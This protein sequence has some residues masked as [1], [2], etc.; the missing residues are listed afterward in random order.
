MINHLENRVEAYPPPPI[1]WKV[2]ARHCGDKINFGILWAQQN[3]LQRRD[4]QAIPKALRQ[5]ESDDEKNQHQ[6][7]SRMD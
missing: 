3:S 7:A 6:Q 2:D 5:E 4:I 1:L